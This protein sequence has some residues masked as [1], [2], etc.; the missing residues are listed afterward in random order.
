MSNDFVCIIKQL[1]S[2]LVLHFS[3]IELILEVLSSLLLLLK[4]IFVFLDIHIER[5]DG[6]LRI[7]QL[8]FFFVK[9][10]KDF[11]E[12]CLVISV[13]IFKVSYVSC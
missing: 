8:Y 6:F 10:L 9:L 3:L 11:L 5:I 2:L 7:L 13:D 1:L 4:P 12:L